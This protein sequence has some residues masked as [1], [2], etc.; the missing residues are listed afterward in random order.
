MTLT[1]AG[2]VAALMLQGR[3]EEALSDAYNPGMKGSVEV[4]AHRRKRWKGKVIGVDVFGCHEEVKLLRI[5][6][7]F[8]GEQAGRPRHVGWHDIRRGGEIGERAR[9]SPA[10]RRT[11]AQVG[12]NQ[13]V[14]DVIAE[15]VSPA[16]SVQRLAGDEVVVWI[17]GITKLRQ[18]LVVGVSDIFPV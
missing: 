8:P 18:H 16:C 14:I 3:T 15:E 1:K 5:V 9:S 7:I 12:A 4:C 17:V 2:K 11:D 10:D 13:P 6:G